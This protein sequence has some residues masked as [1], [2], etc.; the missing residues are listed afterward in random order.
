[1]LACEHVRGRWSDIF[2]F[3]NKKNKIINIFNLHSLLTY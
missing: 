1:M 2:Y 3:K